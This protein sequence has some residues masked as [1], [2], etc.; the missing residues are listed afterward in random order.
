MPQITILRRP[1]E[2]AVVTQRKFFKKTSR[3]KV[4][5]GSRTSIFS[6]IHLNLCQYYE[7][8]TSVMIYTVASSRVGSALAQS[9]LSCPLQ[10]IP[11]TN[12][13]RPATMSSQT[14]IYFCL[15]SYTLPRPISY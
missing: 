11:L 3:G 5:K 12:N 2:E 10:A 8:A 6:V 1:R 14:P 7:S 13:S 15:R 4:I 9:I